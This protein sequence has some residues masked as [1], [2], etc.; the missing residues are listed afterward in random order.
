MQ[1]YEEMVGHSAGG[2]GWFSSWSKVTE[3][4]YGMYYETDSSLSLQ[5]HNTIWYS[6]S[7]PMFGS[8]PALN[9]EFSAMISFLPDKYDYDTYMG[10]IDQFGTH[11]MTSAFMG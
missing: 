11:V 4:F 2:G 8:Q 9:Q 1:D 3:K 7:L 5:T 10:V 6:I